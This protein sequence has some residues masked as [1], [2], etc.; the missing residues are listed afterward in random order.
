MF[1]S[2]NRR[3]SISKMG[4]KRLKSLPVATKPVAEIESF[5]AVN[6]RIITLSGYLGMGMLTAIDVVAELNKLESVCEPV[7]M[8]LMNLYGGSVHEGI[9]IFNAIK[10][11]PCD[12][13]TVCEGLVASMG[14][15]IFLSGK[16]RL[17][18]NYSRLM[19][20]QPSQEV[21]G[22]ANEI[23]ESAAE[24]EACEKDLVD[25]ICKQ[26]GKADTE[27]RATYIVNGKDV[28]LNQTE[29]VACGIATGTVTG[30][31]KMDLPKNVLE[32]S[33]PKAVAAFYAKQI[34]F[35]NPQPINKMKLKP[36]TVARLKLATAEADEA[37]VV[38]AFESALEAA[39]N[40]ITGLKAEKETLQNEVVD[41]VVE[42]AVEQNKITK[43][44]AAEY[45]TLAKADLKAVKTIFASIESHVPASAR[46][47]GEGV[48]KNAWEKKEYVGFTFKDF[49]QKAPKALEEMQAKAP[50]MYLALK[51]E[52]YPSA[53]A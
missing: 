11:S 51:K 20:H 34:E 30:S 7:T 46:I 41:T 32:H 35:S 5:M 49:Q 38:A 23:R 2:R 28:Y 36:T 31:V 45:K 21:Y 26:T 19:F 50:A 6:G 8:K 25:M 43:A 53:T 15:M 44:Q 4:V 17:M 27:V 37:V 3:I 52:S 9:G 12:V 13:T 14:A 10:N 47:G 42:A 48:A 29:A 24:L 1:A 18:A 39:D 22:T 16:S 40:E 33:D